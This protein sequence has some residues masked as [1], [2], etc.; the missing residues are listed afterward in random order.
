MMQKITTGLGIFNQTPGERT[1]HVLVTKGNHTKKVNT[2]LLKKNIETYLPLIT[3]IRKWCDR[4]RAVEQ[5][6]FGNYVF[7]HVAPKQRLMALQT[8]GCARYVNFGSGPA[9]IKDEE[10]NNMKNIFNVAKDLEI[11]EY[12]K[13]GDVVEIIRGPLRGV[14]GVVEQYKGKH[15]ILISVEAIN[16]S[17]AFDVNP[18]DIKVKNNSNHVC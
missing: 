6:I 16:H 18:A 9:V 5:P 15:R 1:W 11:V 12:V 8:K 17:I 10:I 7:V 3:R 2:Q 4:K 14:T 13:K